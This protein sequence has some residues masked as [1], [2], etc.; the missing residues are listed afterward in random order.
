MKCQSNAQKVMKCPS[1]AKLN[2]KVRS[3]M[4]KKSGKAIALPDG[5]GYYRNV[6]TALFLS[7]RELVNV[8]TDAG[9]VYSLEPS[10]FESRCKQVCAGVCMLEPLQLRLE[11]V[12]VHRL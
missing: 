12:K 6:S 3:S 4:K 8:A 2:I 7:G 9:I 1:K 11:F 10:E 5:R